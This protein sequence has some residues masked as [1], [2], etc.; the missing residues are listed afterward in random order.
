VIFNFR[1]FCSQV[2]NTVK[3][4]CSGFRDAEVRVKCKVKFFLFSAVPRMI[5]SSN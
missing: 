5:L 4:K 1:V 2:S 3:T